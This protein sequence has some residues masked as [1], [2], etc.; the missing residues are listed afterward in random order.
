MLRKSYVCVFLLLS[1]LLCF[2]HGSVYFSPNGGCTDAIVSILAQAER[3]IYVQA[4]SFTSDPIIKA[5]IDAHKKGLKVEIVVDKSQLNGLGSKAEECAKAGIPVYVDR[6]HQIAHNKIMVVDGLIVI[7]GSFN[8]TQN[9]EKNNAENLL[10][11]DDAEY[12]Q[13]YMD[14]FIKH[15]EHSELLGGAQ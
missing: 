9:A 14:N 10:I 7:T 5:L 1:S 15:K 4:Y 2:P 13:A 8:F 12:P 3:S 6:K 11:L